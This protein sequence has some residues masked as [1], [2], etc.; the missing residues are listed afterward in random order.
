MRRHFEWVR[1]ANQRMNLT[2]LTEPIEAAVK[3]YLDSLAVLYWERSRMAQQPATSTSS[4]LDIGTGAG[5]PA[6]PIAIMRSAWRVV[7]LDGTRKKVEFV[8]R[9]AEELALGNL[10]VAHAHSDHWTS[11]EKFDLVTSRAVGSLAQIM[12]T[13]RPFLREAGH[14]V[15]YKTATLPDEEMAEAR[16]A[17][18]ELQLAI[19]EPF[20]YLLRSGEA[21][22][23]RALYTVRPA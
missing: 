20:P 16:V 21:E 1:E 9:V 15:A 2:R 22:L 14:I 3:H 13:G 4:L 7:A 18:K 11:T 10:A 17:A 5:F 12:R 19:D 8:R 6:V 23:A